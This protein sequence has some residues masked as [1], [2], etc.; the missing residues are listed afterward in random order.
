MAKAFVSQIISANRL[1]DGRVVFLL[2]DLSGW[3]ADFRASGVWTNTEALEAAMRAA[4]AAE[5]ANVVLD[6]VTVEVEGE[7]DRLK[8]TGLRE[9]IRASL[10]PTIVPRLPEGFTL[11][12][13]HGGGI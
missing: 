7:G 4:K 9:Q 11:D 12:S 10:R 2:P 3:T 8:P 6:I 13:A 5:A 1:A